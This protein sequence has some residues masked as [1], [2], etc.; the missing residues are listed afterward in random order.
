MQQ[1]QQ[2]SLP[3]QSQEHHPPRNQQ[4]LPPQHQAVRALVPATPKS[5]IQPLTQHG[6]AGSANYNDP[7]ELS[8]DIIS[9][10]RIRELVAQVDRSEKLRP[11]I[12]DDLLEIADDFVESIVTAACHLAKH[13][14]SNTLEAR[15][16]LLHVE[17][18][19]NMNLPGF[20]GD[21]IK[22]YKK[23]SVNDVHKERL[24]MIKKS[25]VGTNDGSNAK[26]PSVTGGQAAANMK[27]HA[28]K[29][30]APTET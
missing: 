4:S 18:H 25:M 22:C 15:D 21:E 10:K 16:I 13:R 28:P 12:E 23:P 1:Q 30:P 20:S 26:T 14:K 7:D 2:S 24:A 6:L 27:L 17:R 9:K 5:S 11:E 19:W 8:N 29:T 3:N